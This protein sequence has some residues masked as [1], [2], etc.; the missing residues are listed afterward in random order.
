MTFAAMAGATGISPHKVM[1]ICWRYVALALQAADFNEVTSLAI[2][3][4][5][6]A[7]CLVTPLE[8]Q[9]SEI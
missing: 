2:D 4:R 7:S 8:I 5:S 6:R 3:E 1:A 9:Q